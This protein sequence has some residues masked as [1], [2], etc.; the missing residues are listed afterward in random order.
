MACRD[1]NSKEKRA[2]VPWCFI[3]GRSVA[4]P[5]RIFGRE[6]LPEEEW[7]QRE[8]KGVATASWSA[9]ARLCATPL[10]VSLGALELAVGSVSLSLNPIAQ[11]PYASQSGVAQSLATAVQDANANF[12]FF[13]KVT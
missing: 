9:V 6:K 2:C 12:K 8:S 5:W 11:N 4:K 7:F 1:V 10:S 13:A 3:F